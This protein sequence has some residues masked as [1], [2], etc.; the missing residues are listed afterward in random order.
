MKILNSHKLK[1]INREN[2]EGE[3]SLQR[4]SFLK[5][6][7]KKIQNNQVISNSENGCEMENHD[8]VLK[9]KRICKQLSD[10]QKELE[11]FLVIMNSIRESLNL[12]NIMNFQAKML[13]FHDA[14]GSIMD[15]KSREAIL[16][17]SQSSSIITAEMFSQKIKEQ[18]AIIELLLDE[19]NL[20]VE[21]LG[22]SARTNSAKLDIFK[23]SVNTFTSSVAEVSSAFLGQTGATAMTLNLEN[24]NNFTQLAKKYGQF[25]LLH[26][27]EMSIDF[28]SSNLEV[29][30]LAKESHDYLRIDYFDKP[31]FW[32]GVDELL[33]HIRQ[34]KDLSKVLEVITTCISQLSDWKL[35]HIL[36]TD[37]QGLT[38]SSGI[39]SGVN[40]KIKESDFYSMSTNSAYKSGHGL[41]GRVFQSKKFQYIKDI[42]QDDNFPRLNVA[43]EQNV[44]S[45]IGVPIFSRDQKI[46]AIIEFFSFKPE[47][48]TN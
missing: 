9:F 25:L 38:K 7:L 21:N 16:E 35:G 3:H 48:S 30:S 28:K 27:G 40:S 24:I 4:Y 31:T 45:A 12:I 29:I 8:C 19:H 1:K 17:I 11:S 18:I 23:N 2:R 47:N 14:I 32:D 6:L 44:M 42:T 13:S 34:V 15:S 5:N 10:R 37:S 26:A 20:G 41:P 46:I 36:F 22:E 43:R 39:W 33:K